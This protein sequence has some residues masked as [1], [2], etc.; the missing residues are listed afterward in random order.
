VLIATLFF[1]A[2]YLFAPGK[3]LAWQLTQKKRDSKRVA[4]SEEETAG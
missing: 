4:A 2:A 3:G 1:M